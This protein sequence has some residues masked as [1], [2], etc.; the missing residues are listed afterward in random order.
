MSTRVPSSSAGL[1]MTSEARRRRSAKP[2]YRS[3]LP[4][5][6]KPV[7]EAMGGASMALAFVRRGGW[8]GYRVLSGLGRQLVPVHQR[9]PAG[10]WIFLFH[11]TGRALYPTRFVCP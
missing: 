10:T 11:R 1:A 4:F 9:E 3:A 7:D 6:S 8:G 5:A 2:S